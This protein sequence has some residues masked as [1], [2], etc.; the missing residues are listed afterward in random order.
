LEWIDGGSRLA[1]L[2]RR[3]RRRRPSRRIGGAHGDQH[4]PH[5]LLATNGG[6]HQRSGRWWRGYI[7]HRVVRRW[8]IV[9]AIVVVVC[10]L[11]A[12]RQGTLDEVCL[13]LVTAEQARDPTRPGSGVHSILELE[14][15]STLWHREC[16]RKFPPL[17][18][19]RGDGS[20]EL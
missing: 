3:G 18:L 5:P 6:G 20:V 14:D 10:F 4:W 12:H 11:V 17:E 7:D 1:L 15:E 2:D 19:Y 13:G 16:G 9:V 8:L